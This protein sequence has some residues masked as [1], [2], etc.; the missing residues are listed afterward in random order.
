MADQ[1]EPVTGG[2]LCGAI[3]FESSDEPYMVGY[4]HCDMCKKALGSA[5][6]MFASFRA[7]AFKFTRGTPKIRQSSEVAERAFCP[8]CGTPLYMRYLHDPDIGVMVGSLDHPE[9]W[10]PNLYHYCTDRMVPWL[11]IDDNLRRKPFDAV[12]H[13]KI[14][15]RVRKKLGRAEPDI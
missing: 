11:K 5:V 7:S 2:C 3:R 15:E 8:D 1:P 9:K 14:V 4:C 10:P 13:Q 6:G 12:N